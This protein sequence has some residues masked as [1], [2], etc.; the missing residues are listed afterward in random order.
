MIEKQPESDSTDWSRRSLQSPENWWD[1]PWVQVLVSAISGS[2]FYHKDTGAGKHC[3]QA[4][5]LDYQPTST[6]AHQHQPQETPGSK[7]CQEA[8]F[9]QVLS[10]RA[11]SSN[12]PRASH[13]P[14]VHHQNTSP[15]NSKACLLSTY[16]LKII[17]LW[18]PEGY[19]EHH[20]LSPT[21]GHFSK[22]L[23]NIYK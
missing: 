15:T 10:H 3:L 8:T 7:L 12:H 23:P 20:R 21:Q 2:L 16:K 11:E 9:P 17:W 13:C 1:S 14:P 18:W 4:L 6:L 19:Y 5:H 22:M